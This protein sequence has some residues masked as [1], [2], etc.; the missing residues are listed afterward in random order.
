MRRGAGE[1]GIT[2]RTKPFPGGRVFHTVS[3]WPHP[4]PKGVGARIRPYPLNGNQEGQHMGLLSDVAII[5]RINRPDADPDRMRIEGFSPALIKKALRPSFGLSCYGYD[6]RLADEFCFVDTVKLANSPTPYL[7]P[8]KPAPWVR[9]HAPRFVIEPGGFLMCRTM[10]YM[11]VPRDCGAVVFGKSTWA[12][13]AITLN[14]TLLE[15]EWEGTI[16]LEVA[17]I[18]NFPVCLTAG[19][20]I[21]QV[22]FSTAA[23]GFPLRTSY[24]DRASGR[25][26]TYQGQR[27]VTLSKV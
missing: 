4:I 2:A 27:E 24:A 11:R 12:R 14:T 25:G 8:G 15:P 21:C 10:E 22:V 16:T 18:G 23:D 17:N 6:F 20:G 7:E 13:L 9:V 1:P 19:D 5:D 26:G 3:R